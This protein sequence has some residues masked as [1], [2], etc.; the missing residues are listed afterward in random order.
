MKHSY[1]VAFTMAAIIFA[2]VMSDE[3]EN[4]DIVNIVFAILCAA[5]FICRAIETKKE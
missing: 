5:F 3:K 2:T 4:P 1:W